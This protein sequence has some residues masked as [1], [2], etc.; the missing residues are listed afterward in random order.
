VKL[1]RLQRT[2]ELPLTLDEAWPF[3]SS[4]RNLPA[5]TPPW[6]NLQITGEIPERMFPGMVIPYRVTPAL[7]LSVTW[8]TEITHV[9][10]PCFFVDEQRFGPYRFW[11]HQHLFQ[12]TAGGLQMT[13][14][15]HYGMKLGPL[16][17]LIHLLLIRRRLE[18]IFN[19][20][21]TALV[22]LFGKAKEQG[23]VAG[24]RRP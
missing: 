17:R 18:E 14:T 8:I 15:V 1:F 13:D 19:Y 5:L 12:P 6:L 3:F 11:Q 7:G 21:R 20:R 9:D 2:Q 23:T 22:R 16:G 24:T 4:P 10:A